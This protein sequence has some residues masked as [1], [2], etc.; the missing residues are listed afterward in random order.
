MAQRLITST[1]DPLYINCITTLANMYEEKTPGLNSGC[2]PRWKK[3]ATGKQFC[4]EGC[5]NGRCL[6]HAMTIKLGTISRHPEW[7]FFVYTNETYTNNKI[8]QAIYFYED[9]EKADA[10]YKDIAGKLE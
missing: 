7:K 9:E 4:P 6:G 2:T 5:I 3:S 1:D 10:K 8:N